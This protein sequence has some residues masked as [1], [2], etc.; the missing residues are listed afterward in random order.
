M[1]ILSST[2][3]RKP[4]NLSRH[5]DWDGAARWSP[6]GRAIVFSGERRL[7]QDLDLFYV[8][9]YPEDDE[10]TSRHRTESRAIEA[11]RGRGGDNVKKKKSDEIDFEDLYARVHRIKLDGSRE[12][13]PF[14]AHDSKTIAFFSEINGKRGTWKVGFPSPGKPEFMVGE[15]GWFPW[16]KEAGKILWM[17]DGVPATTTTRY[18]FEVTFDVQRKDYQRLAF[19]K[20]WRALKDGFYDENYHG[21]DWD[22]LLGVYEDMAAS[23]VDW[24]MFSRVVSMLEGELNAS[25]TGFSKN[26]I[27]WKSSSTKPVYKVETAHLGVR[28]D[29]SD[30]GPGWLIDSIIPDGPADRVASQLEVGERILRINDMP[31]EPGMDRTE[32]LNLPPGKSIRLVVLAAGRDLKDKKAQ[33]EVRIDP[34][35]YSKARKLVQDAWIDH[36]R[37]RVSELSEGRLGYLHVDRMQWDEFHQFEHEMYALGYDKEGMVI[38]VR[39]NYGGFTADRLLAILCRQPHAFTQPRGGE[40]SYPRGYLVYHSWEKPIVVLCNQ[41]THS[42]GEIFSHAIKTLKRGKVVGVPTHGGVISKPSVNILDVGELSIPRRGWWTM[43]KGKNMELNGA[44]PDVVIWPR[45]GEI[46][47]GKDKQL[48]RAVAILNRAVENHQTKPQAKPQ[49]VTRE[50]PETLPPE[51]HPDR[52]PERSGKE[53]L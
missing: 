29:F 42:N 10:T 4:Y 39:N 26:N 27:W 3:A 12:S 48:E 20:I 47:G 32:V 34:I 52:E 21:A 51:A 14:W 25:H 49:A 7:R 15:Q 23:A 17:L 13:S 44:Q 31:V 43:K 2:G 36:N 8:H 22:A 50:G 1:W 11:M 40:R 16:W 18:P 53:N 28:F 45:P 46:P 9:L 24:S 41:Y 5:P 19:R 35:S 6:D 38:D 33:R 30:K 37:K